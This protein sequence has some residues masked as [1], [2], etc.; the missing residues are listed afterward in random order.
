MRAVAGAERRLRAG[1]QVIAHRPSRVAVA[2]RTSRDRL[3][4]I[5][6]SFILTNQVVLLNLNNRCGEKQPYVVNNGVAGG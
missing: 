6:V 2:V 5:S 1:G 3:C 4:V